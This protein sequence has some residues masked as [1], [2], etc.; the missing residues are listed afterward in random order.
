MWLKEFTI[1]QSPGTN[2]KRIISMNANIT[3]KHYGQSL[4]QNFDQFVPENDTKLLH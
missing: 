1:R 3:K 4:H 2:R